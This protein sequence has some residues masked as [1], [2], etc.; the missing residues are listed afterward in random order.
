M[1]SL[2]ERSDE[3]MIVARQIVDSL[4]GSPFAIDQAATYLGATHAPLN[5]FMDGFASHKS[6]ILKQAQAHWEYSKTSSQERDETLSVFIMWE[7]S[8]KQLHA[9]PDERDSL[10]H[11]MT[12]GAFI[13]TQEISEGLFSLYAKQAG[14]SRW[15]NHF[16]N[17]TEWDSRHYQDWILHLLTLSLVTSVDLMAADSRFSFHP[18]VAEW[19]KLRVDDE[20]RDQYSKEAIH[21]VRLF[22]DEGDD[23]QMPVRDKGEILRHLDAIVAQD[24]ILHSNGDGIPKMLQG[25]IVSFGSFCRRLGWYVLC[26]QLRVFFRNA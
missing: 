26:V 11:L 7:M 13:D 16:M 23:K 24:E 20:T 1:Q 6:A 25:A 2:Y 17:G 8:L 19:L 14:R 18:L 22:I 12:L 21:V 4:G 3:N 5:S 15:L 10:I 9:S